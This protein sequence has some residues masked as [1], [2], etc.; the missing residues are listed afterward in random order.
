M[1]GDIQNKI[2]PIL[3]RNDVE[4]AAL[5]GSHA[6]G[7]ARADSDVDLLVRFAR[8]KSLLTIIGLEQELAE[9]L[10]SKVDVITEQSL[11]PYIKD[12]VLKDLKIMYG[13]RRYV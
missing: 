6:R 8:P 10:Q 11:H 5:F 12:N 13:E 1:I 9:E 7:E 4:F 3:K 2:I